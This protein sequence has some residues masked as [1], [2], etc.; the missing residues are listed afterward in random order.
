MAACPLSDRNEPFGKPG[1]QDITGSHVIARL[2][3]GAR[4]AHQARRQDRRGVSLEPYLTAGSI[5]PTETPCANL[6]LYPT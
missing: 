2:D 6:G 3:R 1:D 5:S 4:I